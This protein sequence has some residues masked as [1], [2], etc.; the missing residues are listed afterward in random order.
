MLTRNYSKMA[1][2]FKKRNN[3]D[4]SKGFGKRPA[5]DASWS[6]IVRENANWETYYKSLNLI[7]ESEWDDFK[8]PIKQI[9]Q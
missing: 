1:K 4:S 5:N 9:Y 2:N 7:P 6:D 8:K 3:R